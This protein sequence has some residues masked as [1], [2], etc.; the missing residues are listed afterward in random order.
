[1]NELFPTK[2]YF[3]NGA[4]FTPTLATNKLLLSIAAFLTKLTRNTFF[5]AT[6]AKISKHRSEAKRSDKLL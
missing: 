4:N 1:M 5:A 6:V 2:K 3:E